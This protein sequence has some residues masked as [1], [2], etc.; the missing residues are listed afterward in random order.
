M[1]RMRQDVQ[2]LRRLYHV[3]VFQ[4]R[5]K[6]SGMSGMRPT[7]ARIWTVSNPLKHNL[8]M[9]SLISSVR[10]ET[11]P[12]IA[13][14]CTLRSRRVADR[15][16]PRNQFSY[17]W[18]SVVSGWCISGEVWCCSCR[19]QITRQELPQEFLWLWRCCE[20]A[21]QTLQTPTCQVNG[22]LFNSSWR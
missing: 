14:V 15:Q 1:C 3:Y 21:L 2:W 5:Y 7:W 20:S 8:L 11:S 16:W 22:N 4:W 9:P 18:M 17:W 10:L 19:G 13:M 6:S 12:S